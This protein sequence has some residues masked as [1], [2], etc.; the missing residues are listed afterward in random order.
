VL[1][2]ARHLNVAPLNVRI[3]CENEHLGKLANFFERRV[4]AYLAGVT[5]EVAFD[6]AF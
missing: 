5:G 4:S 3:T 1:G 2:S 6:A